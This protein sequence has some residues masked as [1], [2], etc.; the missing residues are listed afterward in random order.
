[1]GKF[2]ESLLLILKGIGIGAA[3]V[4]PG[5]SGGTIAFLTG[6]YERLINVFKRLN[7]TALKLLFSGKFKEFAHQTDLGFLGCIV[8]GLLISAFS[9]A[10]LM[11]YLLHNFPIATWS[12]FLGLILIS[13][14]YVIKDIK[15]WNVATFVSLIIGC[16]VAV[17]VC[18][19]SPSETP[20]DWW[21]IMVC[22]A[23]AICA[24]ILPGISGSF[25]LVLLVKYEYIMNAIGNLDFGIIALFVFGG[26]AGLIAFSH[27]LSWLLKRCYYPT[28]ALLTG[29]MVGSLL[30]IWPWQKILEG[31]GDKA[32]SRPILPS[33][34][35][36]NAQIGTAIIFTAIGI[37][38]VV[39]LENLAA[40]NKQTHVKKEK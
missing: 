4:I 28:M 3:N 39:I 24:M 16:A 11:V 1:M 38:M 18:L 40:H 22:G 32:I 26:V 31:V 19:A 2:A 6:I 20:C 8:L 9:L 12:F 36:G 10:K 29:F 13:C 15:K 34:S 5:V 17:Y 25:I 21:F 7:I 37:I 33:L 27:L 35:E 30:K 23:I 14:Y